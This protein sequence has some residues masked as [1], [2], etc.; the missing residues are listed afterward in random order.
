MGLTPERPSHQGNSN[1]HSSEIESSSRNPKRVWRPL[2]LIRWTADFF[3]RKGIDT[4]RLDAELLLAGV[5]GWSRIDLYARFE[6]GV[7]AD[8]LAQ[9]S[10]L[11]RRRARREPLKY[12]LGEADFHSLSFFVDH[13]VMI[14]RP[15]T[16]TLVDEALRL[17]ADLPG[18]LPPTI[19]DIGTGC[20]NL[21]IALAKE[22]PSAKVFASDISADALEVAKDNAR[23]LGVNEQITFLEG[24]LC[25]PILARGMQ[26]K[27]DLVVSNPPYVGEGECHR[28]Q[29]EIVRYEPRVALIAGDEGFAVIHRLIEQAPMMLKPGGWLLFEIGE[30]QAQKVLEFLQKKADFIHTTIISDYQ[31][32]ARVVKAHRT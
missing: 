22:V 26:G 12:I 2:E 7:P 10:Q 27:I 18:K 11:I 3:A 19:A 4:P 13:R 20:G 9:F 21:A 28:L 6:A 17:I 25:Q 16:E 24:D 29:P 14:P 1:K 30:G 5:L 23:R 31:G 8:K 32:I 15:E